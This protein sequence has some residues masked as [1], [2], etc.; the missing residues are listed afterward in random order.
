MDKLEKQLLRNL[1][2]S[3]LSK[4]IS[5]FSW[6]SSSYLPAQSLLLFA[7]RCADVSYLLR[8]VDLTNFQVHNLL[9]FPIFH[10]PCDKTVD[11]TGAS[12]QVPDSL[13]G[14]C[15][16]LRK[17][18]YLKPFSVLIYPNICPIESENEILH[19]TQIEALNEFSMLT[20]RCETFHWKCFFYFLPTMLD[21]L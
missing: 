21:M 3:A 5:P 16:Q 10:V 4:F 20:L 14:C 7:I 9:H 17:Y 2:R 6:H 18:F 1:S 13:P 15:Y 19:K 8:P 12:A 11:F